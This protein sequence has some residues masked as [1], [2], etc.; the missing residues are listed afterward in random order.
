MNLTQLQTCVSQYGTRILR[1]LTITL[2][3]VTP[4]STIEAHSRLRQ[5]ID[6]GQLADDTNPSDVYL[7]IESVQKDYLVPVLTAYANDPVMAS[8]LSA[9]PTIALHTALLLRAFASDNQSLAMTVYTVKNG[10][11]QRL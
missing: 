9:S 8:L 6:N 5:A 1:D 10:V 2:L 11:L 4:Q 7:S 3:N